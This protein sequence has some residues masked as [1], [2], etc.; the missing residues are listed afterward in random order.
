[1]AKRKMMCPFSGQPC[2]ECA[3]YRGRH[4]Y[5]CFSENYRGHLSEAGTTRL[6]LKRDF[7]GKALPLFRGVGPFS[8]NDAT[9]G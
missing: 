9:E 5:L 1:M 8:D 3:I 7:N 4:Y 6:P 2:R